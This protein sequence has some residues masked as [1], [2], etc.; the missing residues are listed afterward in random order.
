MKNSMELRHVSRELK[1]ALELAIVA[2]CP[3]ELLERLALMAGLSDAMLELPLDSP[4]VA[5]LVPG[6]DAKAHAALDEWER[7]REKHLLKISA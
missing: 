1:T 3:S 7:W 5:A 2:L 6:L 4:A